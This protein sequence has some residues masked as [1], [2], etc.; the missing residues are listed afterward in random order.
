MNTSKVLHNAIDVEELRKR[1]SVKGDSIKWYEFNID[2]LL[3]IGW[4]E[5]LT[6]WSINNA[7]RK[8]IVPTSVTSR[9]KDCHIKL[10][11][12]VIG[13]E[14]ISHDIPWLFY[15]YNNLFL[16]CARL[17]FGDDVCVARVNRYAINMN[18]QRG[19]MRYEAHVDSNPVE[20]LLYVTSHPEGHGGELVV[21]RTSEALGPEEIDLDCE[22]IYPKAGS[23]LFFDYRDLPHYTRSLLEKDAIRA[24]VAMNYYNDKCTENDRPKDLDKHLFGIGLDW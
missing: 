5:Q 10:P 16:D 12:A 15:L 6:E 19:S 1:M 11:I 23:L 13:G 8:F 7:V 22:V 3:P 21:S 4:K 24:V 9:E 18:L 17:C 14:L 20:G 2:D